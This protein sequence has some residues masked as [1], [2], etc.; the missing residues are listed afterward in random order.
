MN[1]I[2]NKDQNMLIEDRESEKSLSG[3]IT[4]SFKF[5]KCF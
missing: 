3:T 1:K 2:L 5:G 4:L